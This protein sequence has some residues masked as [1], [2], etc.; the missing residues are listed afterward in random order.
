MR[1]EVRMEGEN[2]KSREFDEADDLCDWVNKN[3]VK[4]IGITHTDIHHGNT[5]YTLFYR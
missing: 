5:Y 2:M 4:I 1:N 3:E